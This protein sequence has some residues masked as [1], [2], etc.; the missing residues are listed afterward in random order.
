MMNS[1]DRFEKT[2]SDGNA[3]A[4]AT[5]LRLHHSIITEAAWSSTHR[6]PTFNYSADGPQ[7][8]LP[9]ISDKNAKYR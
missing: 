8:F 5:A 2:T 1:F 9:R 3:T 4:T 6:S 7:R